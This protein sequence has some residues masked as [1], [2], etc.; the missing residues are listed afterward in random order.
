MSSAGLRW[1]DTADRLS[2]APREARRECELCRAIANREF[3]L[4]YQPI[5]S[6]HTGIVSGVE[7]LVRW[8]HPVEGTVMP[9]AFI[10]VA[11]SSGLIVPI[12]VFVLDEA[13]RQLA[14]WQQEGSQT[15][16]LSVNVSAVQLLHRDFVETVSTCLETYSIK[17]GKLKLEVTETAK[18][19][20]SAVVVSRLRELRRLGVAIVL[21]DF[22]T[23]YSSLSLL[24][25]LPVNGLKF[26]RSFTQNVPDDPVS[27][28]I[29]THVAAL[30]RDLGL[31]LVIEGVESERQVEWLHRFPDVEVQ[32]YYYSK[33]VTADELYFGE[34]DYVSKYS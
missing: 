15:L 22:G 17:P 12:G 18:L 29:L 16:T 10:P 33:P 30:A 3:F 31:S 2:E 5:I 34:G 8:R 21:D 27:V 26:D 14:T 7:A 19:E 1:A 25:T 13:C 24:T 9:G 23:G 6:L 32:G 20:N 11:E 28:A 4:T